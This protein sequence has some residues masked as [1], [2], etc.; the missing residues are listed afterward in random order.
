MKT[1]MVVKPYSAAGVDRF[2]RAGS[3]EDG[4]EVTRGVHYHPPHRARG[5][6]SHPKTGRTQKEWDEP[7]AVHS[8]SA[9]FHPNKKG[10]IDGIR[11]IDAATIETLE[12]YDKMRD[13]LHEK[14]REIGLLEKGLLAQAF[15]HGTP[16]TVEEIK[17]WKGQ[18]KNPKEVR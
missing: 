18:Y 17:A 14:I 7:E 12:R 8:R 11:K 5:I 13:E 2:E 16:I 9:G 1:S 10:V 6:R 3:P 4:V 15:E